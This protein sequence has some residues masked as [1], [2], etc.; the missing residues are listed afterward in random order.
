MREEALVAI[1][2]ADKELSRDEPEVAANIGLQLE[3]MGLTTWSISVRRRIRDAIARVSPKNIIQTGA[4]IGHLSAWILDHFEGKEGLENFQ[5]IEEGNRFA[6]ILTRL[7][8][9]YSS[10]ST[11]IKVGS[12]GLLASELKAWK[13]SKVGDSPMLESAEA[14]IVDA[15][16]ERLADDINAML[17][18][19]SKNGVLFTVEPNPPVG[20][21]DEGDAEVIGFNKWMELI[22]ETNESYHLAFA[23]LFGGTIVA[24]LPKN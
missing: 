19:L 24:W 11:S 16:M 5:I 22:R 18:L 15:P 12:P 6:V 7:C 23:P 2:A 10:V 4:G 21:R 14:I 9:R 17:P 20:D 1:L 8:Q 3:H 13:I